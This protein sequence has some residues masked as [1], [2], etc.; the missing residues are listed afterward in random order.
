M[1]SRLTGPDKGPKSQYVNSN[2]EKKIISGSSNKMMVEFKSDDTV[3]E[4]GFSLSIQ[5]TPFQN[6]VCQ[7]CL[8]MKQKTLNS[9][10]HPNLYGNNVTCDWIITAQYGLH[11]KLELQELNVNYFVM[12]AKNLLANTSHCH[13]KIYLGHIYFICN[14]GLKMHFFNQQYPL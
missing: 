14:W 2:W 10:N 8:D 3:E 1:I 12:I 4:T 11:I 6:D 9:P 5:F 13:R 7:L